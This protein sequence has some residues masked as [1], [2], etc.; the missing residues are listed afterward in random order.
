MEIII[1]DK[2]YK[3]GM[4]VIVPFY[5]RDLIK[6]PVEEDKEDEAIINS[7]IYFDT[8]FWGC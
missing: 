5:Q 4:P 8:F 2:I 6:R 7:L 3:N 1:T